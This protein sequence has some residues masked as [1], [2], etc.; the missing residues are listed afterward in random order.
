MINA[1]RTYPLMMT[2]S[3]SSSRPWMAMLGV[4]QIIMPLA[5]VIGMSFLFP[6][7]TPP[8]ARHLIT[9]T[10][11]LLL[12]MVG[13]SVVP[14]MVAYGRIQGTYDFMLSL[15]VP[16]ML[17]L[18]SDATII[19]L[20]TLPGII[21]A[22]F[23]GSVYHGF[24]LQV[25]PLVVPVFILISLTGTFVGYALALAVPRPRMTGVVTNFLVFFITFFSPV[26]YSA[27][28][29]PDWMAAIH[30]VLPIQYMADLS[31]GTL[32]D[33]PVN[34]GLAFAVT[35]AWCVAS[36]LFCYIVMKRRA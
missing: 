12:L 20:L 21:I 23:I 3:W 29:L 18:A 22:L 5:F 14:S 28:Q 4:V 10:P 1:I 9:G 27:E 24:T 13:L 19:F 26:I 2:W 16:R 17:L 35:G 33:V 34:L 11:T 15:P 7:I 8:I 32:S 6:D 31:R 36:F 30:R 25:S